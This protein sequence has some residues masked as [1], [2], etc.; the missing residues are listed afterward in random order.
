M[1]RF[2][3]SVSL[4]LVAATGSSPASDGSQK[5]I[6]ETGDVKRGMAVSLPSC[7]EC[8]YRPFKAHAAAG[9][10]G[11]SDLVIVVVGDR[12]VIEPGLKGLGFDTIQL[13]S[14]DG[15]LL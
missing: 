10:P 15:E 14:A 2:N 5:V 1:R 7:R 8:E 13:V 12:K 6:P 3:S 9:N 4:R 11:R